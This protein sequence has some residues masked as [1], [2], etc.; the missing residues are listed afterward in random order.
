ML[1][2]PNYTVL[3]LRSNP[4]ENVK[5]AS[6]GQV[7]LSSTELL[8]QIQI[9]DVPASASVRDRYR[10]PLCQSGDELLVDPLLEALVV[11]GVDQELAAV[12]LEHFDVLC[13][14]C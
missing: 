5:R 14:T 12:G 8:Y 3:K 1:L 10:A 6:N 11:G 9:P 2:V 13:G 7:D 4:T